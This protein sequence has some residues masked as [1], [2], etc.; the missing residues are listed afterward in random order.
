MFYINSD[1]SS[2]P[3]AA[4]TCTEAMDKFRAEAGE[5]NCALYLVEDGKTVATYNGLQ[6]E[7]YGL[8]MD[9]TPITGYRYGRQLWCGQHL[10]EAMVAAGEMSPA[11]RD[12][13]VEDVLDQLAG[14][15]GI[16]RD[17]EDSF[18]DTEFP[19]RHRRSMG[20]VF[21]EH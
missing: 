6:S 21:C 20:P 2:E 14:A 12:M 17:D 8:I 5:H 13:D 7:P 1:E 16:D 15:Y 9:Q 3:I 4:K 18:D 11:A 19:K 10:I